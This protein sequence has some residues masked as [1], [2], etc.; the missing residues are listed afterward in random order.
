MFLHLGS[1][2]S[3]WEPKVIGIFSYKSTMPSR[4]TQEFMEQ[5]EKKRL[6]RKV[7]NNLPKSFVLTTKDVYLSP[8]DSETL[9]GRMKKSWI[10]D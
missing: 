4:I 1:Q 6:T 7:N 8:I 10:A 3:V 2:I 9:K 5:A